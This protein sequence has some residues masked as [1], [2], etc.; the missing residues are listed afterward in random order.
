MLYVITQSFFNFIIPLKI[1][2]DVQKC[3]ERENLAQF[4]YKIKLKLR[5][6]VRWLEN[7]DWDIYL[8]LKVKDNISV[9]NVYFVN[10]ITRTRKSG[11]QLHMT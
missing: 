4:L 1:T 9:T 10:W 11:D 8:F 3:W 5:N 7:L 6:L 2:K